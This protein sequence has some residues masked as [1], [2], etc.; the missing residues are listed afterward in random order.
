M[1]PGRHHADCALAASLAAFDRE[2]AASLARLEHAFALAPGPADSSSAH[3]PGARTAN[4]QRTRPGQAATHAYANIA[5]ASASYPRAAV[6][7]AV[8]SPT[9][10]SDGSGDDDESEE[11]SE[12]DSAS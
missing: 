12:S 8:G 6:R 5:S 1:R 11:D 2:A 4:T 10:E 3:P 9:E 7:S